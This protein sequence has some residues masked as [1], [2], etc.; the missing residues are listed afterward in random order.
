VTTTWL[1]RALAGSAVLLAVLTPAAGCHQSPR[2]ADPST[3]PASAATAEAPSDPA[4]AAACD[5]AAQVNNAGTAQVSAAVDRAVSAGERGDSR[6][7]RAELANIATALQAW[8]R[9]LRLHAASITDP[10]LNAA[11]VQY[12][13]AAEAEADRVYDP[14]CR[15]GKSDP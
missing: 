10:A 7:Q 2:V 12:A 8:A 6:E 9:Q 14:R 13:G 4:I 11:L 3:P 5:T 15:T 1:R